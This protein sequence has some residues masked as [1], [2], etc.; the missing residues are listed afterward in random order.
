M[1]ITQKAYWV[2][3]YGRG[4]GIVPSGKG[5][6]LIIVHASGGEGWVHCNDLV[7]RSDG[8]LIHNI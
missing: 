1:T 6:R 3:S 4:R 5:Q 8:N 2:D 7:I